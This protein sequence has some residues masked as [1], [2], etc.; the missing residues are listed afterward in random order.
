MQY[1]AY[2]RADGEICTII[3]TTQEDAHMKR[4]M[5]SLCL[6]LMFTLS[7]AGCAKDEAPNVTPTPDNSPIVSPSQ[8]IDN[9]DMKD[10]ADYNADEHGTVEPDGNTDTSPD[11]NNAKTDSNDTDGTD[12]GVNDVLDGVGDATRDVVDGVGDAARDIGNGVKDA[13]R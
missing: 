7:L 8:A 11:T 6:G 5:I 13:V 9:Q 4:T 2:Y 10:D 3:V 12:N 1:G